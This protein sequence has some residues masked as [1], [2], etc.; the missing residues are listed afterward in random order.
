MRKVLKKLLDNGL[1]VKLKKCQFHVQEIEFLGYV[2]SIAGIAISEE[3]IATILEWPVPKSVADI[4]IFNG[5]A[6]YFRRFIDG[7]SRVVTP[8]TNLLR[9]STEFKWTAETQAAFDK[10]KSLFSNEPILRHFDPALP[11]RLHTDASG[12]AL[13]GIISQLHDD[14]GQWHPVAF[15]SRKCTP[16]ECNYDTPDREMLA[17]ISAM[18]H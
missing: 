10:L 7:Y 4:Q 3:R 12:F 9:K 5:V 6:N 18:K 15:W 8:L 14:D 17:I 16:A 13:S 1:Y 2:L 11:I